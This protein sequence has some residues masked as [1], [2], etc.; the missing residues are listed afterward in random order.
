MTKTHEFDHGSRP[1]E[2]KLMKVAIEKKRRARINSSLNELKTLLEVTFGQQIPRDSKL[3]KAD[4]LELAVVHLKQ[5][6]RQLLAASAVRDATVMD[7]Y[8]VGYSEC[9]SEVSRYMASVEG[10]DQGLRPR[11]VEHLSNKITCASASHATSATR[12]PSFSESRNYDISASSQLEVQQINR[13]VYQNSGH[14]SNISNES[15][16]RLSAPIFVDTNCNT[17][18]F[19][20][21]SG[22]YGLL[23]TV[24]P[25]PQPIANVLNQDIWR[26]W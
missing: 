8:Q 21:Y 10:I 7:K 2:R 19:N 16:R 23:S 11:V 25:R 13:N 3:E 18:L 26:P 14:N 1:T 5:R 22:G 9:V 4:I 6:Q 12:A 20:S 17:S 15:G 24:K